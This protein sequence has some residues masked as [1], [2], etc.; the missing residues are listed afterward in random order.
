MADAIIPES[1]KNKTTEG[2]S[3][4]SLANR[5]FA[6]QGETLSELK[7][8]DPKTKEEITGKELKKTTGDNIFTVN[9]DG[10]EYQI[11]KDTWTKAK[12]Y[13]D[14]GQHGYAKL[15]I[16]EHAVN[17]SQTLGATPTFKTPEELKAI[18]Q[19]NL[20][21]AAAHTATL[22]YDEAAPMPSNKAD[23]VV[24]ET[25]ENMR[26]SDEIGGSA[27][28]PI[29]VNAPTNNTSMNHTTTLPPIQVRPN[30]APNLLNSYSF[31]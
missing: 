13:A 23:R 27:N 6:D 1:W 8:V 17:E 12:R 21:A 11:T 24:S 2:G 5:A 29:V 25:Q 14:E 10:Q 19:E 16:K 20:K 3:Q 15:L 26:L 22:D 18:G 9:M 4:K 7:I 30:D 31:P 28:A